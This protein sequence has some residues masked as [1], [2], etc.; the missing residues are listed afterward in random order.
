MKRTLVL[1]SVAL[2]F[3]TPSF[4]GETSNRWSSGYENGTSKVRVNNVRAEHGQFTRET[5]N[6]K[7]D[8]V[9]DEGGTATVNMQFDNNGVRGGG[10]ATTNQVDPYINFGKSSNVETGGFT[11]LTKVKVVTDTEFGSTYTEHSLTT[12]W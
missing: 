8:A 4:A 3:A 6:I 11:D 2:L 12:D 9:T 7:I 10:F 1:T 5:L